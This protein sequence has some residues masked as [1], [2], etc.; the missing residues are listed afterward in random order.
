MKRYICYVGVGKMPRLKAEEYIKAT[1]DMIIECFELTEDE[2]M[3][4]LPNDSR[5]IEIVRLS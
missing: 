4:F 5:N 3:V 1:R 2:R